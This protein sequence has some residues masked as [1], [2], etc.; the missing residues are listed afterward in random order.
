MGSCNF[1]CFKFSPLAVLIYFMTINFFMYIDRGMVSSVLV[2]IESNDNGGLGISSS[3]AGALGSIFI[4]GYI[5]A[6]PLFAH[7]S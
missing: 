5:I 2:Q 1:Y 4:V 3:E 6:A 7:F